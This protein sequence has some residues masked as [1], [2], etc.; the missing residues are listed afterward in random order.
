M[1]IYIKK[2]GEVLVSRPSGREAW[3]A[4]QPELNEI[5]KSEAVVVDFT[6]VKVLAPGWT[7]EFVT[8]LRKRFGS[9]VELLN[10][11]NSSVSA[12]LAFLYSN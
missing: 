6:G 1:V 9:R 3:L 2:F 8:P 11:G 4:Y 7:D 5:S 12:S 10:T